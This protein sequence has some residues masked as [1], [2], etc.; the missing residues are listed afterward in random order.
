MDQSGIRVDQS[1]S[2]WV[3]ARFSTALYKLRKENPKLTSTSPMSSSVSRLLE[4]NFVFLPP[5]TL[6]RGFFLEGEPVVF[7][8]FNL[9]W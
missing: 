2:E 3:R 4:L 6:S 7:F 8:A 5:F 1:G 9:S